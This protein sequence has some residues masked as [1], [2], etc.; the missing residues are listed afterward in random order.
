MIVVQSIT[1]KATGGSTLRQSSLLR[2]TQKQPERVAA[3]GPTP[4]MTAPQ[5]GSPLLATDEE[6]GN[7]L[8]GGAELNGG[9][10][11]DECEVVEV[12]MN[13]GGGGDECELVE[14][15][16]R[17]SLPS[18][19][20]PTAPPLASPPQCHG[21]VPQLEYPMATNWP[22][23]LVSARHPWE[24][25]VRGGVLVL[26]AKRVE[27]EPMAGCAGTVARDGETCIPCQA[28]KDHTALKGEV[29]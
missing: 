19:E 29:Q 27:G 20:S 16:T 25:V 7:A 10:G 6:G 3:P 8:A 22:F 28:L 2:F 24:I 17:S 4:V 11:G 5:T 15:Q 21:Y 12:Q 14:V 18:E 9:G 1:R 23:G 26:F 13:G